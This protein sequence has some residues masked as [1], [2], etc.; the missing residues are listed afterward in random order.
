MR[1]SIRCFAA[2]ALVLALAAAPAVACD[3]E[4]KAD[5]QVSTNG[6]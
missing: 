5:S 3:G 2:L 4:A 1:T 6:K